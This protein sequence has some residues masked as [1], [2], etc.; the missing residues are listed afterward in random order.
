MT[1]KITRMVLP[2]AFCM[3]LV[4][5]V[6]AKSGKS[7]SSGKSMTL[8]GCLQSGSSPN[9][10]MLSNVGENS[11]S[12]SNRSSNSS[13]TPGAMARSENSGST[14]TLIPSGRVNLQNWVGQRVRVTGKI[15]GSSSESM[16]SSTSSSSSNRGDQNDMSSGSSMGSGSEFMVTSVK[17]VSGTCQ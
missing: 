4:I 11:Q 9:T 13:Q 17:K 10:F 1:R 5:G 14:Y 7:H 15:S 3:A 2:L 16:G 6:Q 8:T 12:G